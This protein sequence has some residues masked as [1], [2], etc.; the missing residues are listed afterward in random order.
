MTLDFLDFVKLVVEKVSVTH[1][2]TFN[3]SSVVHLLSLMPVFFN[4][5]SEFDSS[6]I[7]FLHLAVELCLAGFLLHFASSGQSRENLVD[8]DGLVLILGS[9]LVSVLPLPRALIDLVVPSL[10][11]AF[12]GLSFGASAMTSSV[13]ALATSPV[14]I[15]L[16]SD[17]S[18]FPFILEAA[19]LA[20]APLWLRVGIV[21]S[22][23]GLHCF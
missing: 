14:I 9:F 19:S 4:Q 2:R 1:V 6:G 23:F 17:C 7:E 8:G 12:V 15:G 20:S 10:T 3:L 13:A 22:L 5:D 18:D 21:G 11:C 16:V